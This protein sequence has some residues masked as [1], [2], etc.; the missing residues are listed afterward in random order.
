M[1]DTGPKPTPKMSS[2]RKGPYRVIA[3]VKNDVQV[4]NL[5][6]YANSCILFMTWSRFMVMLRIQLMQFAMM[7]SD[8]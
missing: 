2:R 6:T 3:Q 7:T 1:L 8:T 4:C 5:I